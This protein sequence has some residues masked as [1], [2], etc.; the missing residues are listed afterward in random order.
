[1]RLP[2][3]LKKREGSGGEIMLFSVSWISS[4]QQERRKR[5]FLLLVGLGRDARASR[6]VLL[7][8]TFSL[9]RTD[10]RKSPILRL[11]RRKEAFPTQRSDETTML[12]GKNLERRGRD[13][14]AAVDARR[15]SRSKT[16]SIGNREA[17]ADHSV[18][19]SIDTAPSTEK[20]TPS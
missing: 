13:A 14:A 16:S 9:P 12:A 11:M 3:R 10:P 15:A 18:T 6:P 7:Q 2:K 8:R 19:P 5:T 4:E 20:G 17:A 1:M